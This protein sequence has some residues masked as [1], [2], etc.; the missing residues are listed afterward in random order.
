ML[1]I[2]IHVPDDVYRRLQEAS[3]RA[4]QP[5]EQPAATLIAEHLDSLQRERELLSA[6]RLEDDPRFLKRIEA[7][8]AQIRAGRGVRLDDVPEK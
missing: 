8:R 4:G 6:R 2:T 7:A 5:V 3:A 1:S